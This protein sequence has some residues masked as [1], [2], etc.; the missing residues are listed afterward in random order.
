LRS[1]LRLSRFCRFF[2]RYQN[3]SQEVQETIIQFARDKVL[4][5]ALAGSQDGDLACLAARIPLRFDP[6]SSAAVKTENR[7]VTNHL[8]VCLGVTPDRQ[9]ISTV[10][11]SEPIVAEGARLGML[12]SKLVKTLNRM[13]E[14]SQL[15]VGTCGEIT[16][17]A[18]LLQA[19]DNARLASER[20]SVTLYAFLKSFLGKG[21]HES[22]ETDPP[23]EVRNRSPEERVPLTTRFQRARVWFNHFIKIH[24]SGILTPQYL[25]A[26]F[27]R[28]IAIICAPN[29]EGC[30]I[31]IPMLVDDEKPVA[32]DNVTVIITQV[33]NDVSY[34]VDIHKRLFDGMEPHLLGIINPEKPHP[35]VRVVCAIASRKAICTMVKASDSE[36]R[37]ERAATSVVNERTEDQASTWVEPEDFLTSTFTAYDIWCAGAK[38]ASFNV[39]KVDEEVEYDRLLHVSTRRTPIYTTFDKRFGSSLDDEREA[40]RRRLNPGDEG[41]LLHW[42]RWATIGP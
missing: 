5:G 17:A 7:L 39:I 30:F 38:R 18:L 19:H 40:K 34:G 13:F 36:A 26:C 4:G 28:G 3:G 12:N 37:L 33:K 14:S 22:L 42:D 29:Q 8:R 10:S 21:A 32:S 23:T 16:V 35:V 20:R 41:S 1:I 9:F 24:S 31:V 15:D 11:A 25:W 27:V 6:Y 2:T